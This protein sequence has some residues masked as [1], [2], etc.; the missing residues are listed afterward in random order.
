MILRTLLYLVIGC[1]IFVI[2]MAF[3]GMPGREDG[4]GTRVSLEGVW[5]ISPDDDPRYAAAGFN[6]SGWDAIT[7]P[8]NLM[9]Y[10]YG[11]SEKI[12]GVLWLRKKVRLNGVRPGEDLGLILGRIANADE[13]YFNGVRIGGMGG[14]LPHAHSMWNHPRYYRISGRF[15]RPGEENVVAVRVSYFLFGDV[16]GTLAVTGINDWSGSGM[17]ARFL[18]VELVFMIMAL[19]VILFIM[20]LF[21]SIKR[22]AEQEYL[23]YCLQVLCGFFIVLELCSYWDLY[24]SQL[25]RQQVLI[26]AWVA[27]TAVHPIFLHRVYGLARKKIE[28]ALWTYLAVAALFIFFFITE[29]TRG[30][31]V[32]NSGSVLTAL[33]CLVGMYN[34]SCHV[35]ALIKKHPYAKIFSFFGIIAIMGALHDGGI[36]FLKLTGNDMARWGIAFQYMIFPYAAAI[37][38]IGSALVLTI[39][40]IRMMDEVEDLNNSLESFVIENA[41]L[42]EK[43]K[44]VAAA[45]KRRGGADQGA[46]NPRARILQ[47]ADYI[48][49]NY[50][51]HLSRSFL[52][53]QAEVHPDSLSRLFKKYTGK[54]LGDYINEL[55][56]REAADKLVRD[57]ESVM[58]IASSV[59]F[60][61]IR[62]FN[63]LFPRYMGTTPERY[64]RDNRGGQEADRYQKSEGE[65]P[66]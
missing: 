38:F 40:F 5:K 63:R 59:G 19:G 39:R 8:S 27:I 44:M 18:V 49:D 29:E 57:E 55:R 56:M 1:C 61:S 58:T 51:A 60:D 47:V 13:T 45:R 43:L 34:I 33:A 35:S 37:F 3:R 66:A 21:F 7:L 6:D 48:N 22:P 12:G 17:A 54:K 2:S 14:F 10:M 24:G 32:R 46:A 65:S 42:G 25:R 30:G 36:F 52:A 16:M 9:S 20:Y 15:I 41:L 4:G 26:T 50:T 53:G 64:R 31:I 23:Y 62:T 28:V 11:R